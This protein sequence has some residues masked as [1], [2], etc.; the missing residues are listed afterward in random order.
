MKVTKKQPLPKTPERPNV[1]IF[2]SIIMG[3]LG[4]PNQVQATL[5]WQWQ[6]PLGWMK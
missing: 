6:P 5:Q 4:L 1:Q 2:P 3:F